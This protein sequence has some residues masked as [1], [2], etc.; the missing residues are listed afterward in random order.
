MIFGMERNTK[1][2]ITKTGQMIVIKNGKK[3]FEEVGGDPL[4]VDVI[5]TDKKLETDF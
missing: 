5:P 4:D 1:M 2:Q 3:G